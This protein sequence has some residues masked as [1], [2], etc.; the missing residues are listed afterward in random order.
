MNWKEIISMPLVL[1]AAGLTMEQVVEMHN[2]FPEAERQERID[3]YLN[4]KR[5]DVLNADNP[6][7]WENSEQK[8]Y[9]NVYWVKMGSG[10]VALSLYGCLYDDSCAFVGARRYWNSRAVAEHVAEHF[11]E[12]EAKEFNRRR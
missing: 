2:G 10:G 11:I 4:D 8:K 7:D 5:D 12:D 3:I 1:Q 9:F 6:I